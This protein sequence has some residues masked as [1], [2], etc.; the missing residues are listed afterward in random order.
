M[1]VP[2]RLCGPTYTPLIAKRRGWWLLPVVLAVTLASVQ[3]VRNP[4]IEN[5]AQHGTPF[6]KTTWPHTKSDL[7]PDPHLACGRLANGFRYILKENQT[8]RDRVSMHLY[9][10]AGSLNETDEE[11]GVAHFL[12]HMLF[13]G[14]THFAPGEM[15]KFFQRI[16]MQFGPDANAHTGFDQTVFDILL[17]DG[18]SKSIAE[19]LMVMRDYAAGALLDPVETEKEKKVILAEMR[20]RDSAAFRMLKDTFRFEMQ[21]ALIPRRFPIGQKAILRKIDSAMLRRF[22]DTWYRPE[23]MIL[24]MVGDFKSDSVIP[25]IEEGFGVLHGRGP[26]KP[27]PS[28]GH[29]AH[30]GIQSFYRYASETGKTTVRIETIEQKPQ[31]LDS[32]AWQREKLLQTLADQIIQKRLDALLQQSTSVLASADVGS[33]IYLQQI[34]YAG[35]SA[36]CKPEYW[37]QVLAVLDREL[38]KALRFGFTRTEVDRARKDYQ[39]ELTRDLEESQTRDSTALARSIMASLSTWQVYQSPRQRSVLFSPMLPA[40]S[41]QQVHQAFQETWSAAHR[42]ILVTGNV[43]L[44]QNQTPPQD[45]I[46]K[47]FQ[48]S[49]KIAVE[50]PVEAKSATFPYLPAIRSSAQV[51]TRYTM[52]DIGVTRVTFQ[53]GVQL[54]FKQTPFKENQILMALSFGGGKASEPAAQ[55]G[56]AEFT[57]AVVN[58]SG[59]GGMNRTALDAAL[60]G[61]LASAELEVR[62]D[63]FVVKGE[64]LRDE[65]PLLVQLLYTF[66]LDPG[67]RPE[68]RRLAF[69][70]YE[71]LYHSMAFDVEG[72][73]HSDG[74]RF[75]ASGDTR[76]GMPAWEQFRQRTLTQAEAWFDGQLHASPLELTVVGDFDP[77][78]LVDYASRFFGALP[79]REPGP[80]RSPRPAPLFPVGQS[81]KLSVD[82]TIRKSLVVVAY[83]T[84]DFWDIGRTRRLNILADV[85]TERLREHVREKLG[86]AYSPFAYNRSYRAYPG[87]GT[88]QVYLNVAPDQARGLL[89]EVRRIADRLSRQGIAA[90]EFRRAL[91]PTLTQIKDLRQTNTYWLNSVLI[92]ASRHPDQLEW[93]RTILK[94]YTQIKKDE[95]VGLARRYL[96][97]DKAATIVITSHTSRDGRTN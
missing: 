15:V 74:Q 41:A 65:L 40:I 30:R 62:E 14:S 72:L 10:Q 36:D 7:Q 67:F 13:N 35:V 38:R 75:L 9:V 51:K 25:L 59:F 27:L 29:F 82:S 37:Q 64:A 28:I 19:G 3:C 11:Q 21:G 76:F 89:V 55:P 87:F 52:D 6:E 80:R 23:R 68:A 5:A 12:E 17:P 49:Q 50:P 86:A 93:C 16:G 77:D 22:Y 39:A 54:L 32:I 58:A 42:L 48:E 79:G 24:V 46:L 90:D 96:D 8:P 88:F 78:Q 20:S 92:G 31:P 61:H 4:L 44:S 60:A 18:K 57:E 53:N 91:D 85:F 63:S 94:D 84:E 71:Q 2:F 43:D 33:G 73:M 45:Q 81:L 47:A 34:K 95:I 97:N 70:R 83:P 1:C 69:N 26:V 56:L 66:I